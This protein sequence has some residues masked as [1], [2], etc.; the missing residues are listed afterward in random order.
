M[1]PDPGPMRGEVNFGMCLMGEAGEAAAWFMRRSSDGAP[2][3][4]FSAARPHGPATLSCNKALSSKEFS[5]RGISNSASPENQSLLAEPA[6]GN[7]RL[8]HTASLRRNAPFT[9]AVGHCRTSDLDATDGR[10]L[11]KALLSCQPRGRLSHAST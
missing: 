5:H 10:Y 2:A 6:T 4:S 9:Y 7:R 1:P 11:L 3:N 8:R